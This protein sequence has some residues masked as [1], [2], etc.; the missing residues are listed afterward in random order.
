MHFHT[1][2]DRKYSNRITWKME[3]S[4]TRLRTNTTSK[5]DNKSPLKSEGEGNRIICEKT[6]KTTMNFTM[7]LQAV[8]ILY[9]EE[10]SKTMRT[11]RA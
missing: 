1:C 10:C 7:H 4:E 8:S 3:S 9:I 2:L 6:D 11:V 5:K